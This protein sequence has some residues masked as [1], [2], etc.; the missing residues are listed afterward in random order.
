MEVGI[1]REALRTT[2]VVLE[3]DAAQDRQPFPR[4]GEDRR[5]VLP[6][7]AE[8]HE[9]SGV[10]VAGRLRLAFRLEG[11]DQEPPSVVADVEVAVQIAQ[12]R[13][14]FVGDRR[15]VGHDPHVL[16]GVQRHRGAGEPGELRCP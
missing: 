13:E 8:L 1:R 3:A 9:P 16:R 14:P 11:A 10:D 4:V 12:D 2:E 15:L 7:L 6:V 5:E